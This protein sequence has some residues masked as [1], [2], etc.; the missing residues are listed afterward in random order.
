MELPQATDLHPEKRATELPSLATAASLRWPSDAA[1]ERR[2]IQRCD[3]L[4]HQLRSLRDEDL[5]STV[6]PVVDDHLVTF[7]LAA[8]N[9]GN[10]IQSCL[11]GLL[12]QT[13]RNFEVFVVDDASEDDTYAR[14]A[15][16]A[17]DRRVRVLRLER[18]VGRYQILNYI[19]SRLARG[20]YVAMQDAD[21]VSHPER[22]AEQ[23]V[24]LGRQPGT[25]ML[26][27]CVHQ[28]FQEVQPR[29]GS[30]FQV[31]LGDFRHS[32]AYYAGRE[33]LPP[34]AG[35]ARRASTD[36]I[37]C[38]WDPDGV[39]FVVKSGSTLYRRELLDDYGGFDGRTLMGGDFE[40]HWRILRFERIANIPKVLYSRRYHSSSLTASPDTG[41]FSSARKAFGDQA[42]ILQ[43]RVD[44]AL[45][46]GDLSLARR[47][48]QQSF[49]CA[50][51]QVAE[52]MGGLGHE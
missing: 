52:Q 35:R 33:P 14:L 8:R 18:R 38:G 46:S 4:L 48:C 6:E 19:I 16:L 21:D 20:R 42:V 23:L 26:G 25:R 36:K 50:D 22:L 11:K 45:A 27:T 15:Q 29:V 40:L 7:A 9:A 5:V 17:R 34:L 10:F 13:H 30:D 31:A 3:R 12:A 28:F 49:Y 32:I 47:L 51:V 1:T 43:S 37:E 39:G 2:E 24:A 41:Y 44:A